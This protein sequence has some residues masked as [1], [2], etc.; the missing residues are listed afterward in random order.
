M[1]I[2]GPGDVIAKIDGNKIKTRKVSKFISRGSSLADSYYFEDGL[3]LSV[4]F[5]ES[6]YQLLKEVKENH[7]ELFL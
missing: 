6:K 4:S 3:I 7:P 1:A 2:F 5:V